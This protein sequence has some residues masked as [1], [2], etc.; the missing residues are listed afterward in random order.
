MRLQVSSVVRSAALLSMRLSFAKTCSMGFRSGEYGGR[1]RSFAPAARIAFLTPGPLWLPRLSMM[2][3]SP[4]ASVGTRNC[5]IQL[6]KLWPLM[7]PSSTQGASMRSDRSA[8]TKVRVDHF[9]KGALPTSL[10]PRSLQPRVGV[11]LVFAHVSSMKTRRRGS[12]RP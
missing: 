10:W 3:I 12:S 9:P 8:A 5:S 6:V 7:G 1:K 11:M 2:T 4:G